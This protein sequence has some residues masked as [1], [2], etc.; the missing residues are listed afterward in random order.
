MFIITSTL[1]FVQAH[2]TDTSLLSFPLNFLTGETILRE[3][4]NLRFDTYALGDRQIGGNEI[5][6][7]GTI[8]QTSTPFPAFFFQSRSE[9]KLDGRFITK[10]RR[11]KD[12]C[13]H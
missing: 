1:V 2:V 3:E 9:W 12:I 11:N 5:H 6:N 7:N 13:A 4:I 8:S 10:A